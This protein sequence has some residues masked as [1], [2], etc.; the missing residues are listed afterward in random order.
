[1]RTICLTVAY[2]G[3]NYCGWQW[4]ANGVSLQE[5][6]E[7]ALAKFT[8]ETI[9]VTAAGRTDAGVHALAQLVSFHTAT[10]IPPLGFQLG[11]RGILPDDIVIRDAVERPYGYSARFDSIRKRYRYVIHN[12]RSP[13]PGLRNQ[14]WFVRWAL[15]DAAMQAAANV[16]LGTHDFRCFESK[17]PNTE[18]SVRTIHEARFWRTPVWQPWNASDHFAESMQMVTTPTNVTESGLSKRASTIVPEDSTLPEFLC[19]DIVAN[20]FLYNMV[21]TIVGT[22]VHVGRGHWTTDDIHRILETGDRRYAGDT[23]PACGLSLVEIDAPVDEARI[24]DRLERYRQKQAMLGAVALDEVLE[25]ETDTL[26]D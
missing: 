1:M 12:A 22:L 14:T 2:D 25:E 24:A 10:A 4:Q 19:F 11:L 26:T 5:T 13:W 9:R 3:T 15:D 18:S 23:A 21:R 20:G 17:W 7:A 8:G 6:L 16:L